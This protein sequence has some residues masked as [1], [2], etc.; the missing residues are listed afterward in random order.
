MIAIDT[1]ILVYSAMADSPWHPAA[2]AAV[3]QVADGHSPWAIP[4]PCLHEFLGIVA[5]PKIYK[6][7]IS[8][9]DAIAQVE[10]WMESPTLRLLGEGPGYWDHF[11]PLLLAG[12]IVGPKVHDARIAAICR[13]AGV[14]EIWTA[15]RDYSRFTG[16]PVRNLL[17]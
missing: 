16:M 6:P 8:P 12:N 3:R 17:I 4:W 10:Y 14:H 15:D 7:P 2:R 5:H 9:R 1:N 11:K 13:A